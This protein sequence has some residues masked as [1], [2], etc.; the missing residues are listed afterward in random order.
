MKA[1]RDAIKSLENKEETCWAMSRVFLENKNAYGLHNM[2]VEI[3]SLQRAKA[4]LE[5]LYEA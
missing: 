4:E 5:K 3:Q 1:I 2:S